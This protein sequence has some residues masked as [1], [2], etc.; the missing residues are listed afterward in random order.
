MYDRRTERGMTNVKPYTPPLSC[1]GY[2]MHQVMII[3]IKKVKTY[4]I[5]QMQNS[6]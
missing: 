3:I 1:G 4:G 5:L 2:K 6:Q